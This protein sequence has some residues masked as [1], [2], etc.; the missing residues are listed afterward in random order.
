[1]KVQ[2]KVIVITGGGN[3]MG[4]EM[5][6]ILLSK[7]AMVAAVDMNESALQETVNLAGDKKDRLS[8]QL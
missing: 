5:V 3:G 7:G 6:L 1:V 8:T 2:N 4:R